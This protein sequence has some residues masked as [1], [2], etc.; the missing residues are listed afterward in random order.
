MPEKSDQRVCFILNATARQGRAR[1][2]AEWLKEEAGKRWKKYEVR[3]TTEPA[4][5]TDDELDKFDLFVACGGDGTAHHTAN[6][7]LKL[8]KLLGV[9][10]IGSGNDFA[11]ALGMPENREAC[12][13][14]L[15]AGK[16]KKI[17]LI[18]CSGDADRWCINTLGFGFDGLT[19]RYTAFYKNYLG[20]LGYYLGAI[21]TAFVFRGRHLSLKSDT[22]TLNEKLLMVTACNGYREGGMFYVAPNAELD[23]GIID[24]L[25]IRPVN[26]IKLL[27]YLPKFKKRLPEEMSELEQFRCTK[28][29]LKSKDPLSVHAD[30]EQLGNE[31]TYLEAE[32][33][34]GVL[35]VVAP[36]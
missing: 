33:H 1:K 15:A 11:S 29:T 3:I 23:D 20:K 5:S 27:W 2:Q 30:G 12:L 9:L 19:N 18:H 6:L 26:L 24:M 17:D 14:I 8:N 4:L 35:E 13:D 36:L 31:I 28:F 32:L 7:A 16:T 10:P 34:E 22:K 21:H 25:I